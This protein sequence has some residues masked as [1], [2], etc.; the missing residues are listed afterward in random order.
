[1]TLKTTYADGV[2][3]IHG[4]DFNDTNTQVN[5]N[6]ADI[7][8]LRTVSISAQSDTYTLVLGD[9]GKAVEMSATWP[10]NVNVPPNSSVAFPV[11]TTLQIVQIGAG[12]VTIV[13]GVGV[14]VN[15]PESLTTRDQWSQIT[16][17]KRG[18]NVWVVSGDM[19]AAAGSV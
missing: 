10:T 8:A 2:D 3:T 7:T 19:E 16:L 13:P 6:T 17:R 1:M 18:T 15:T 12:P 4:T 11:G 14:T 9:A 5:T